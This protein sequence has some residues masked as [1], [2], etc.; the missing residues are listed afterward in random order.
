M[1][2]GRYKIERFPVVKFWKEAGFITMAIFLAFLV[3]ALLISMADANVLEAAKA[4]FIGAFGT[5]RKLL[6]TL[7]Q[8]TPLIFTG[9]AMTIAF[10]GRVWNVGAEGQYIAG[11]MAA[12]GIGF[13]LERVSP[14]LAVPAVFIAG[15][16]AGALV[17]VIAAV[18]KA[19]FKADEIIVTVMLNF[20]VMALLSYLLTGP[21]QDPASFYLH[22]P[23]VPESA[24]MPKLASVGNLHL[25]FIL[26]L[27][28]CGIGYVVLK[29][30][31]F[32]FRVRA[33]GANPDAA[34]YKGVDPDRMLIIIM[35]LSGAIAGLGGAGEL[36][37]VTYRLR[38][39]VSVG[40]GYT[41]IIIALLARLNPLGVI[42]VA[43][44]FGALVNGSTA[45]QVATNVPVA[46]VHAIQAII[47][48]FVIA[49]TTLSQYRI[50]K[51]DDD[52]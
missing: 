9:L 52:D 1:N 30:T 3:S 28:L 26:G 14:G 45:M 41:G 51:R 31:P 13:V 47:L 8:A 40:F 24:K 27:V 15:A 22:T 21:W 20:I 29:W 44:L 50:R 16:L 49:A 18:I 12:S 7:V 42:A 6:E 5:S 25:G 34:E 33:L 43:T 10:R 38:M 32:G 37:G 39:D 2:I 35:V 17:A 23:P 19:K 36:A 48:I 4:L 11:A 46:L